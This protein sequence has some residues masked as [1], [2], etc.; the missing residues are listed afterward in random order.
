MAKKQF[1]TESKQLLN[2]MINSI[3]THKEIFLR[4]IISNASDAIDKLHYKAITE[5]L[6]VA[7]EDFKINV[8]WDEDART[9]TVSDNGIGMNKE[10][11]DS[12]LGVI[13]HSG[14]L[15]FKKAM[16]ENPDVDIIGQF[17]VG[18]YS[19]FLVSDKVTVRS[20]AYGEDT[21]WMWTSEGTDGYTV[22]ECDKPDYG[23]EV[24]MH[25]KP[26]E[27]G[28]NYSDFI[29]EYRIKELIKKYSDYVRWPIH[30]MLEKG[31]MEETGEKDEEGNPKKEWKTHLEDT[32]VNSMVPIW[33]RSKE[34]A[35]DEDC[36]KFYK[37]KFHDFEDPISVIRVNAEGTVSYKAMLFIPKVAPYNFYS[38]DFEPGLQLYSSGVMIM[39]K[40]KDVLPDCFRFVRGV[41]DSPD[42]SL[43]I[44]REMLQHDR[45]LNKIKSNIEKKI[46]NELERL[47]S[48]ERDRYLEFYKSFGT[49]VKYGIV[50][51][52]GAKAD[53]VKDLVLFHSMAQDR[54]ITL[55]EYVEG[56]P[57]GQAKIYYA[58]A[59]SVARAK[60]LPQTEQVR[61]KGYDILCMTE[62]VDEFAIRTLREYEEKEFCDIAGN[63]LGLETEEEKKEADAKEEEEKEIL[64]FVKET[65][66]DKVSAVKLSRKLKT[67]AVCLSTEGD[68]SLEMEKYFSSIPGASEMNQVKAQRVLEINGSH[69]AYEALKKAYAEDKDKAADMAKIMYTQ[70]LLI[71]GMPVDDIMDYSDMVFKLF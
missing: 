34:D 31:A 57:E 47:L 26:D 59:E 36:K 58:S 12:N 21:A 14:S 56:M 65:I 55:K 35:S 13:A 61:D 63:D 67:H 43:N 28:E 32:V 62:D 19:A 22:K 27:D 66:G 54:L 69:P 71:A 18:F 6:P 52:Y 9:I 44:S 24:E 68:V 48:D 41:V 46:K 20:K 17:G 5:S 50:E 49:Q 10:D 42:L 23:T 3:Y 16:E 11:M 51:G 60:Q 25:I 45:Q 29:D 4:E 7:R 30:M 15:D 38:R 1:K 53:L 64:D 8:S 40:C 37:E 33:Q 39:D 2:L 70:A